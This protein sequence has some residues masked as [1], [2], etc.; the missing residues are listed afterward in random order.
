MHFLFALPFL[1]CVQPYYFIFSFLLR[2]LLPPF[3]TQLLIQLGCQLLLI[4]L[5]CPLFLGLEYTLPLP[6]FVSLLLLRLE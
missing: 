2:F 1:F 6:P 4:Q 5:G 3:S